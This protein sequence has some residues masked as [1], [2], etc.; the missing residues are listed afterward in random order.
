MAHSLLTLDGNTK[1]AKPPG[2]QTSETAALYE[3]SLNSHN[4]RRA[5]KSADLGE[6]YSVSQMLHLMD[7]NLD[8]Y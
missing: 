6:M 1:A 3:G 5:S 4:L 7:R 8:P 2:P